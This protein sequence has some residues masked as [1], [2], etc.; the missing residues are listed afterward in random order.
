[1]GH[2]AAQ[3]RRPL[4]GER[5]PHAAKP[6]PP[7]IMIPNPPH[8]IAILRQFDSGPHTARDLAILMLHH[9]G[10]QTWEQFGETYHLY[11]Q[12]IPIDLAREAWG[13]TQTNN[14][15]AS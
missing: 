3:T 9:L 6:Q 14:T 5:P 13:L 4:R 12:S 1:M 2:A 7:E 10:P 11:L 15:A 8:I